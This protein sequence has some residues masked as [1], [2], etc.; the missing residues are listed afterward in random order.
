MQVEGYP[1]RS[2]AFPRYE[3]PTGKIV[4]Q[5][6]TGAFGPPGSLDAYKASVYYADDRKAAAPEIEGCLAA[7]TN[8]VADRYV[9]ANM[10]HQGG[11]IADPEAKAA[12]FR[13]LD[14]LEYG[15]NGIP[16]PDL[17]VL[18]HVPAE[19]AMALIDSRGNVKD[20]HENDLDHLK[21]AEETFLGI[22]RSFPGFQVIEC[23]EDGRLLTIDEV[24]Q[25]VWKIVQPMLSK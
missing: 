9:A 20:G 10:G 16:R 14:D 22:A 19:T 24:H 3:T 12:Y 15:K 8:V 17:N 11:K 25:K 21:H 23:V 4:K 13:W 1:V 2:F 7:G 18:L 6:L 5:Y